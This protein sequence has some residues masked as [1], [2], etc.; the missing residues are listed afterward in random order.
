MLE[1]PCERSEEVKNLA[2]LQAE[3]VA[4]GINVETNGR[5]SKEPFVTALREHHWHQD[6]P[7]K[8]LPVQ[9]MPMLLSD[10]GDLTPDQAQEIEQDN[11]AW[12][13]Q[14]KLDGVRALLHVEEEQVRITSRCVSEVNYRINELQ[15]NLLHLTQGFVDLSGT[16]LDGE[17]VC[18][19]SELLTGSTTTATSLQ[20]TVAILA[21][22]PENARRIQE[23][24]GA[25]LRFHVF[26]ILRFQGKDVT[27]LPLVDR[28]DFLAQAL[29]KVDNCCLAMVPT[30]VVGKTAVHG[31]FV[32]AGGEGTVWKQLSQ[33]YQ[34]GR[35]V[36]HWI[37]RKRG[38]EVEA[39]VS[40]FKP[41]NHGHIG[42]VGAVEFSTPRADGPSVPVAWVSSWTDQERQAITHVD[43]L[44]TVVLNPVFVGRRALIEGQGLSGK[45]GRLRHA[46]FKRWLTC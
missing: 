19:I 3:C 31:S 36:K 41:G 8:P 22:A 5:A 1:F 37:K 35:R 7:D 28:L 13:S 26:D 11:H 38:I 14:P 30:F 20:A 2:E 21:T 27:P 9:V 18:P 43:S 15:D 45:A 32:E 29:R 24:Q 10:W 23:R 17:L 44:G 42:L 4:L 40:G 46:R 12:I 16:I 33:P 6:H 34:S 39:F 25:Q